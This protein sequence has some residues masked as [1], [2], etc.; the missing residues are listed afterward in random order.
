MSTAMLSTLIVP[1][2]TFLAFCC[3]A[4]LIERRHRSKL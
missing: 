2:L 4:H 1:A 3:V